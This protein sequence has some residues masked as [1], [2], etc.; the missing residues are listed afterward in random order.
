MERLVI[1]LA[2][3]GVLVLIV[4]LVS[5]R[6]FSK[7]ITTGGNEVAWRVMHSGGTMGGIMLIAFSSLIPLIA[8]PQWGIGLF[9]WSIIAGT[10]FFISAMMAAAIT[11]ERGLTGGG[12]LI[13]R[14]VR[15]CYVIG[16]LLSLAGCG[17]LLVGLI[18]AL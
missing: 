1:Y 8:L 18:N 4:S 15:Y 13:N 16:A 17:L 12:S 10:W 7:A 6:W 3:H 2:L 5:G 11:G 9:V 14:S